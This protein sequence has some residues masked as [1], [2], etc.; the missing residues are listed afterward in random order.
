MNRAYLDIETTGLDPQENSITIIGILLTN[1]TEARFVQLVDEEITRTNLLEALKDVEV[2]YTYNGTNFDIPFIEY[3]LG[4]DLAKLLKHRDL[5]LVCWQKKLFG[6]LKAVERKLGITRK[7]KDIDG[8]GAVKLWERYKSDGDTESLK[9]LLEYNKEDVGNL[10]ILRRR[11]Q[12]PMPAYPT[13]HQTTAP[14]S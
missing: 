7:L 14:P 1:T 9:T 13:V 10:K 2:I 6:G 11:L 5:M 4:I 3:A 8:L 12:D